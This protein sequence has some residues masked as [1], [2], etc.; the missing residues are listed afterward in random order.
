MYIIGKKDAFVSLSKI[1]ICT[2]TSDSCNIDS[3]CQ[4]LK[5]SPCMFCFFQIALRTADEFAWLLYRIIVDFIYH[6]CL[7]PRITLVLQI[8]VLKINNKFRVY[9]LIYGEQFSKIILIGKETD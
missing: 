3:L 9:K 5:N 8:K 6:L 4:T 7:W 2:R 1:S